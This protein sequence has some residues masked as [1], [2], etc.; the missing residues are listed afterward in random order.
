[1]YRDG[2]IVI[3]WQR[4]FDREDYR[5]YDY[6]GQFPVED[7]RE[8]VEELKRT[9]MAELTEPR[10]TLIMT[11]EGK[12]VGLMFFGTPSPSKTPGGARLSGS[13]R[14]SCQLNKMLLKD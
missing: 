4:S 3:F 11:L 7:Y 13:V 8:A 12:V 6:I 9:G 5:D 10:G 2:D 14:N 1:M